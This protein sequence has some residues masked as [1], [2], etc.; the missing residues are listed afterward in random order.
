MN[1]PTIPHD[2][3]GTWRTRFQRLRAFVR[4]GLPFVSGVLAALV[5]LWLYN[6]L[7]PRPALLTQREVDDSIAQ[8]MASATP[9]PAF[10][11]YVYQVIRP[12][13]VLIETKLT[14]A[15][16][17]EGRGLG[18]GVIIDN[19]GDILTSLHVV[20]DASEIKVTFADGTESN[21]LVIVSQPENDIAVLQAERP[22]ELLVP[23][24]LGNPNAM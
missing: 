7:T 20:A 1:E 15:E 3:E 13:L 12:S 9:G 21:A 18:S 11:S 23:A 16:G 2:Q 19:R 10:S 8:A 5:A 17:E 22:P 4:G 24:V 14:N 6:A